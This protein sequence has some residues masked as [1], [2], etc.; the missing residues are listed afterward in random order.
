MPAAQEPARCEGAAQIIAF[1][2]TASTGPRHGI[3]S[4]AMEIQPSAGLRAAI[5]R[6]ISVFHPFSLHFS[7]ASQG[8][9]A[10][11]EDLGQG[12]GNSNRPEAGTDYHGEK[13]KNQNSLPGHTSDSSRHRFSRKREQK[14]GKEFESMMVAC[15]RRR[16][17]HRHS[18]VS[19]RAAKCTKCKLNLL[20]IKWLT[21]SLNIQTTSRRRASTTSSNSM[22]KR[23]PEPP[24]RFHTHLL[25]RRMSTRA[26]LSHSFIGIMRTF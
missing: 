11:L 2:H 15:H 5:K 24:N 3:V 16:R 14:L 12:F 1:R 10:E 13:K 9:L 26:P 8:N 6:R 21:K 25:P 20:F 4:F 22:P 7:H 23:V 18:W 19:M 17:R